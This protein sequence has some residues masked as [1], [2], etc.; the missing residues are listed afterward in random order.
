M[1]PWGQGLPRVGVELELMAPK[2]RSRLDLARVLAG[3]GGRV[4]PFLHPD[5]EP[6]LV[7]GQPVFNNLTQGFVALDETGVEVARLVDDITLQADLD[8]AAPPLPGWWR[9]VSDDR[10]LLHLARRHGRAD[11]GLEGV[12]SPLGA[13]FGVAVESLPGG[14]RRL[15]DPDGMPIALG[16][17]LPGERERPCEIITPPLGPFAHRD[18][19]VA[20]LEARLAPARDLGFFVPVE[21]AVHLHLDAGPLRN[22]ATFAAFVLGLAPLIPDLRLQLGTNPQNRRL[23]AWPPALLQAVAQPDFA[24]L[25]WPAALERLRPLAL[26]K[27]MDLNLRNVVHDVPGKP[28]FEVRILPGALFGEP[29]VAGLEAFLALLDELG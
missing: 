17:P 3:P 29:V 14:M 25:P 15:R 9:V 5:S 19:L 18:A 11:G 21:A 26:S 1:R 13:L 7:P 16:A 28:T 23:G 27:Y 12:L 24:G 2:G 22:S 4:L 6:S 10:R 20:A 8:P